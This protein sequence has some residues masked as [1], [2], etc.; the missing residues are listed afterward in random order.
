M[1]LAVSG[2]VI[3]DLALAV[4]AS[5]DDRLSSGLAQRSSQSIGVVTLVSQD[6]TG[7]GRAGEQGR[8]DGDVGDV[9][10]REDQ[11]EGASDDVGEGVD[12]ARLAAARRADAL[13]ASP[14]FPPKA[15]RWALT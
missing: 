9:A 11:G 7:V 8:S 5:W 4:V 6:V 2:L 13:R 15:E 1:S 3:D 14:P 12:L 10:G